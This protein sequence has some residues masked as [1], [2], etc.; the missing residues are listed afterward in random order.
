MQQ[1]SYSRQGE[2]WTTSATG[3]SG[4][5]TWSIA[6]QTIV[7]LSGST[8]TSKSR[9][10]TVLTASDYRNPSNKASVKVIVTPVSSIGWLED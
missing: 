3:G 2:I 7:S 4:I 10:E 8:I 5:Y 1:S 6:D 9:G